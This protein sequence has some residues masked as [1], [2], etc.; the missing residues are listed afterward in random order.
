MSALVYDRVYSGSMLAT[1]YTIT[2]PSKPGDYY[3][4]QTI[5]PRRRWTAH[6]KAARAGTLTRLYNWWRARERETGI[7]PQ[8]T[9]V[10]SFET[11]DPREAKAWMD[12][13][14]RYWIAVARADASVRSLNASAGGDGCLDPTPETRAKRAAAHRGRK[15][16]PETRVKM[17]AAAKGRPFSDLARRRAAETNTG[18]KA[19]SETRARM[20]A[21]HRARWARATPEERASHAAAVRDGRARCQ[22]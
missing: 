21:A 3:I 4:G 14:E 9:I 1:I 18:K 15:N 16:T 10:C 8:M 20:S 22:T 13:T 11:D 19:S 7:S 17:S 6:R 5:A 2:H 12:D